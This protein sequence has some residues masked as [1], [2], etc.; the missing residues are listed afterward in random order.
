MD[1]MQIFVTLLFLVVLVFILT[2]I[3]PP[4]NV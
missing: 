3:Q 2:N 4:R 1:N